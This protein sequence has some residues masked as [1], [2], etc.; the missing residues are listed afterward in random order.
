MEKTIIF[1]L[2]ILSILILGVL[3]FSYEKKPEKIYPDVWVT[4]VDQNKLLEKQ[5]SLDYKPDNNKKD[6]IINIDENK[7]YQQIDG[8]GASLTDSSAWLIYNKLTEES[9]K[10]LINQLFDRNKGIGISFIR[11]PM[12]ASDYALNIYSYDD[13]PKEGTDFEL[14]NFS[15][16]H[17]KKYII[18]LIKEFMRVNKDLKIMASPWSSPGWMKTSDAMIGGTLKL[19]SYV[20]YAKYFTKFIQDY[21]KE[22]IPIYA[23][24]PQNEPLYSPKEYPGMIMMPEDQINFIKNNLGPAFKT[25]GIATKIIA[26][27]HNWDM[28]AYPLVVLKEPDA[29]KYISGSAWHYYAGSADAMS[30][31]HDKYPDKDVWFTEGSGGEWIPPVHDA[32]LDQMKNIIRIPRNWSKSIVWWNMALDEKNGPSLLSKSTCRGIVTIDQ[33]TGDIKYNL[34]YYTLGHI[35]KFVVPGAYRIDSNTYENDIEDVAF[36][37]PDG[38][39]VLI[40]SNRKKEDKQIK[41]KIGSKTFKYLVLGESAVTFVW[42]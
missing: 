42:K 41:V 19:D 25:E 1:G 15:I 11:Q 3:R 33:N 7:L 36:K 39:K 24:T 16:D 17:D 2:I 31:I 14:K 22:G 40:V 13:M 12:G 27:D 30:T 23:I 21:T 6:Y 32:F 10:K 38:S 29:N 26:Y 20:S 9:R 34:D 28:V 18:P 37:N 8:F 5:K 35:S 4:T